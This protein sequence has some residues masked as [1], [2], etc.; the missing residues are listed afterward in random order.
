MQTTD[1]QVSAPPQ[2]VQNTRSPL[3]ITTLLPFYVPRR[4]QQLTLVKRSLMPPMWFGGSNS[5]GVRLGKGFWG[6]QKQPCQVMRLLHAMLTG[7]VVCNA[8]MHCGGRCSVAHVDIDAANP[9]RPM[10]ASHPLT[11]VCKRFELH[12]KRLQLLN[13]QFIGVLEQ[14]GETICNCYECMLPCEATATAQ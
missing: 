4:P 12:N 2:T 3:P 8:A 9:V 11:F 7:K 1:L 13:L 5:V 10:D 6:G 14:A